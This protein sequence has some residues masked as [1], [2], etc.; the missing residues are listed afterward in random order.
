MADIEDFV[1]R[2]ER[3]SREALPI[4]PVLADYSIGAD[5][6][7]I[8]GH[9]FLYANT[10]GR[11]LTL[12]KE[13]VNRWHDDANA[14]VAEEWARV[15]IESF[16]KSFVQWMEHRESI[17]HIPM[18]PEYGNAFFHAVMPDQGWPSSLAIITACNPDGEI[19]SDQE[20][21][22]ATEHLRRELE[23][24]NL[25]HFP[26]T[27]GSIDFTHAEPGFGIVLPTQ[28]EAIAR[29][30]RFRQ[31]AIFWIQDGHHFLISCQGHFIKDLG[32]WEKRLRN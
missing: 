32:L 16:T 5:R 23:E 24:A 8:A 19:V 29:G 14:T 17:H 6:I 4:I 3:L 10:S 9:V 13:S 18:N 28:K 12:L 31:E 27:G 11:F 21:A 2:Q 30:Q 25:V 1:N 7:E 15:M 26:V 22:S 20:N